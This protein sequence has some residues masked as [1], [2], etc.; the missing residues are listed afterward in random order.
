M[1]AW[2]EPSARPQVASERLDRDMR[3]FWLRAL[4]ALRVALRWRKEAL[5]LYRR[6]GD[7]APDSAVIL[8]PLHGY[9]RRGLGPAARLRHLLDHYRWFAARTQP[10]S[11]CCAGA[12]LSNSRVSRAATDPAFA[13]I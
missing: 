4:L 1:T 2:A 7:G 5:S 9:L 10:V 8:K 13:S 6:H 12:G 11:T 3:R